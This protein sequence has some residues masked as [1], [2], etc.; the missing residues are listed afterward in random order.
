MFPMLPW[1]TR[2][3]A[4]PS[5]ELALREPEGLLAA[6]G[7]LDTDWL[8]AAYRQGIFPW[9]G[10]G[11][12]ILWWS[13]D[14]RMVLLP[15]W[16]HVPHSLERVMRKTPFDLRSD[17]AFE[18][19]VRACA[20]P[21]Q[22][23]PGTWIG[24]DMIAA[25]VALHRAGYAHSMESWQDDRLVGGLYG[26]VLGRVFFGE[27]MFA[28]VPDASKVAFVHLV[29]A[30]AAKGCELIDCQMYT[31]HLA[32]FGARTILRTDFLRRLSSAQDSDAT[33]WPESVP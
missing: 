14:P 17:T 7:K 1:L 6:G 30:L 26:V 33:C 8:L 23:Q 31:D 16:L 29:R 15:E 12:P 19:V 9:Y 22:N 18:D 25:Y 11:Q 28:R 27:S 4:F 20:A 24:E 3:D 10:E 13:P 5:P 2:P 32:R 21:R